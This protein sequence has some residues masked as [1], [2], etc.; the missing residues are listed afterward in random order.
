MLCINIG[1]AHFKVAEV[2]SGHNLNSDMFQM[3]KQAYYVMSPPST[4]AVMFR[5]GH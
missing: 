4:E 2:K 5:K 3:S 1:W